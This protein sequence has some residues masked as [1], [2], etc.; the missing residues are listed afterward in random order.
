[1]SFN[2]M[3][4]ITICSDF[5]AQKVKS[6]TVSTVCYYTCRQ[7]INQSKQTPELVEVQS[8]SLWS[9]SHFYCQIPGI[10]IWLAIPKIYSDPNCK[11]VLE[12]YSVY[13]FISSVQE[14]TL[15]WGWN[16]CWKLKSYIPYPFHYST[17]IYILLPIQQF[18]K[19]NSWQWNCPILTLCKYLLNKW[20]CTHR[21]LKME[22][23]ETSFSQLV[24]LL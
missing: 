5:G 20:K 23:Q 8:I 14:D 17:S 13:L 1:M 11:G 9:L 15:E 2:F 4:A 16:G 22:S 18:P 21:L 24:H 7:K 6:D 3:A 10:C 19:S 12:I